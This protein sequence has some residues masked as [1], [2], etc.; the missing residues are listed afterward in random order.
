MKKEE[1]KGRR[2]GIK[3]EVMDKEWKA[4]RN[5]VKRRNLGKNKESEKGNE[6]FKKERDE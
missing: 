3:K 6:K 5:K 4:D 1:R 2:Q